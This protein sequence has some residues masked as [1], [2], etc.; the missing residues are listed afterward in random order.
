MHSYSLGSTDFN[1]AG[2]PDAE[3]NGKKNLKL[4]L[5]LSESNS[6]AHC[7]IINKGGIN[8]FNFWLPFNE[9]IQLWY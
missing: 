8:D 6:N 7:I 4:G 5:F 3:K 2:I 9:I 1:L